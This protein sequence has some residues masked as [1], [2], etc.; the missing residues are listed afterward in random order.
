MNQLPA[1][2]ERDEPIPEPEIQT[3]KLQ[4]DKLG[5]EVWGL[6]DGHHTVHQ[7][8]RLFAQS[9]RL[10]LREAEISVSQYI[11]EL[12]KRGLIGLR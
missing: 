8:V 11:R 7:I 4:L 6:I 12:G 10:Q 2:P 3:K 9:H 1:E 5:S